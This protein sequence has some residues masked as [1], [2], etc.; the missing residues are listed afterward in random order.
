MGRSHAVTLAKEGADIVLFDLCRQLDTVEYPMST[1]DDL[2]E[3]ANLVEP[4]PF[5][6]GYQ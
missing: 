3:T 1:P 4:N 5:P 6:K 2:A